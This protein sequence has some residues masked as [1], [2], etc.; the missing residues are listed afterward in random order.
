[1]P[2]VFSELTESNADALLLDGAPLSALTGE[3]LLKRARA[4]GLPKSLLERGDESQLRLVL[5]V[6]L[7][8]NR[9]QSSSGTGWLP[10]NIWAEVREEAAGL[11]LL[12]LRRDKRLSAAIAEALNV[13]NK[14]QVVETYTAKGNRWTIAEACRDPAVVKARKELGGDGPGS[15]GE[16]LRSLAD[17]L[18]AP[19]DERPW[20]TSKMVLFVLSLAAL[21]VLIHVLLLVRVLFKVH[22]VDSSVL[23]YPI[24]GLSAS[25]I[26]GGFAVGV[27][28]LSDTS[29]KID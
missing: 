10:L 28:K 22:A 18:D 23:L 8:S 11:L 21:F 24:V 3:P 29:K 7:Q 19:V 12:S 20:Y 26:V 16:W 6:L 17:V 14:P 1:M 4:C 25:A 9:E 13:I 27:H 15:T 2:L 5:G